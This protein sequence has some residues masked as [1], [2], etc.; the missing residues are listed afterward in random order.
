MREVL[1]R[2]ILYP[3]RMK[4][5]GELVRLR[6]SVPFRRFFLAWIASSASDALAANRPAI[7]LSASG[8]PG[9]TLFPVFAEAP[10]RLVS[11]DENVAVGNGQGRVVSFAE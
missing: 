10:K 7:E 9:S 8:C 1:F 6:P 3:H 11:A 4:G 5:E 2:G